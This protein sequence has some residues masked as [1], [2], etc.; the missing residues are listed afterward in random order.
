M[1]EQPEVTERRPITQAE[2]QLL[3]DAWRREFP[4]LW[5]KQPGDVLTRWRRR[6]NHNRAT[7]PELCQSSNTNYGTLFYTYKLFFVPQCQS[8]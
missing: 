2:L 1:T 6:R 8:F 7:V 5:H 4:E 3:A